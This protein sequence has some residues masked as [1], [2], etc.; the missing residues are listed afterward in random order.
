MYGIMELYSSS[1]FLT[2]LAV[3][4]SSQYNLKSGT[5]ELHSSDGT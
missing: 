4:A 1:A 2:S 3:P 5:R